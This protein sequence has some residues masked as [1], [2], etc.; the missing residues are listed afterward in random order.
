MLPTISGAYTPLTRNTWETHRRPELLRLFEEHV[1][2]ITPKGAAHTCTFALSGPMQSADGKTDTY[3]LITTITKDDL[4]CAFPTDIY[5]PIGGEGPFPAVIM[6][7]AFSQTQGIP[8]DQVYLHGQMPYDMLNEAGIIGVHTHVDALCLD[9]P[10]AYRRG[11]F[12]IY[13]PEGESGWGAV[14]AWAWAASRVVDFLISWPLVSAQ[15]IA[16]CGCSRS[17]KAALWCS[18]QDARIALTISNVSGCTGAAITR[19]K[20][21]ERI[22]DITSR[23]PHWFCQRYATYS[24]REA[25]LPVDQHMLLALCGPRPLYVSS[26]SQDDWADPHKEFESAVLAGEIQRLYGGSGLAI[27][28]FPPVNTP[29]IQGDVGYHVRQGI[30]GCTEYDWAQYISFMAKYFA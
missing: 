5:V 1:Y 10:A 3:Q 13:P 16:I 11:L 21:G 8:K 20:T 26:A 23:F 24:G 19:G 27:D 30:H 12:S 28:A 15:Q 7:D 4:Q 17:G 6:L 29:S 14:G 25:Q 22:A 2:G 18:A 9:D